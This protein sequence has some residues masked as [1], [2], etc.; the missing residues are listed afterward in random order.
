MVDKGS[1]PPDRHADAMPGTRLRREKLRCGTGVG[2]D[3]KSRV[4]VEV[5]LAL[6]GLNGRHAK[7]WRLLVELCERF[8]GTRRVG[9]GIRFA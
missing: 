4:H 1:Q 3:A 9:Y 2:D 6:S 8:G 7:V 5:F